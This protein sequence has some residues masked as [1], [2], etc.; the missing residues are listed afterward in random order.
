MTMHFQLDGRLAR[1][2][3]LL[4]YS[5]GEEMARI[6]IASDRGAGRGTDFFDVAVFG[7]AV[8]ELKSAGPG[9]RIALTGTAVQDVWKDGGDK[10]HYDIGFRSNTITSI[11]P[12]TLPPVGVAAGAGRHAGPDPAVVAGR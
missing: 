6:T 1:P 5:D 9:D 3:R 12:R 11:T 7:P 10:T 4:T 2:P 8:E